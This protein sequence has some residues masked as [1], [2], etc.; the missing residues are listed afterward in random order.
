MSLPRVL[1]TEREFQRAPAV[2]TDAQ[3]LTCVSVPGDEASLADAITAEA[4]RFVIVG[5]VPYRDRLY[6]ALPRGGVIARFGVGYDNI[7]R[8]KA[9][10]AGLVCTN[11]PGVLDQSVAELTMLLVVA[12]ARHLL[13]SAI[14]MRQHAWTQVQGIELSG[15]TLTIVG[16]G[17]IGGAVARIASAGFG[18]RVVGYRR[19]GAVGPVPEQAAY[20][21]IVSD[22][23]RAVG[24]ADFVSVHVPATGENARFI[25][26]TRLACL[27]PQCWLVNTARGAVIDEL[28]LYDA[29][30]AGRISGAALDVFQQEPYVPVDETRDLRDLE[31]VILLP[32]VGSHTIEANRRMGERALHNIR[33]AV[34]GDLSAMDRIN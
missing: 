34:A 12:A 7:D 27:P 11:T 28:A 4:A 5:G 22:F 26:A 32:H 2:F 15:R 3:G 1:V 9:T 30:A 25:D 16:C 21:E 19:A 33:L 24:A 14:Q 20:A 31:N 8:E 17:R 23:A 29:L 18:M 10:A 6:T 13:T